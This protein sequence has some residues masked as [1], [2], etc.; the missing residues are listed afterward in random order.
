MN[1][2]TDTTYYDQHLK[3]IDKSRHNK[4]EIETTITK[5]MRKRYNGQIKR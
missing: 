2:L 4:A 3:V 1:Y 5:I